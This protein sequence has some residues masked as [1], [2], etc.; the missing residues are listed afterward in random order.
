M[1]MLVACV[2]TTMIPIITSKYSS[3]T[4]SVITVLSMVTRAMAAPNLNN[5][6]S[7]TTI[8]STLQYYVLENTLNFKS[9]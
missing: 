9:M 3:K 7:V 8:E 6:L 2:D 4:S 1:I 5:V